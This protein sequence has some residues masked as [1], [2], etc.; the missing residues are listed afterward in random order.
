[1]LIDRA[2]I[3]RALPG[4]DIGG[5]IGR[6]GFGLVFTARHRRLGVTRAVKAIVAPEVD[7]AELSRRFLSEAQLMTEL[8]HP[9]LVRVFEYAEHGS[10]RLLVME[11]LAGGTLGQRLHQPVTPERVCAW[12]LAIADGLQAAHERGVAHRDIKPDNVLFTAGGAPKLSDFGIAK[13]FEGTAAST[14]G[15]LGTPIY[16]A[17]EQFLGAPVGPAADLYSLGA[18]LYRALADRTPVGTDLS[19][20]AVVRQVIEREPAP[21]DDVPSRVAAV[22]MRALAKKPSDRP[23][24]AQE[25]AVELARAARDSFG[26]GWITT[27]GVPLRV[28]PRVLLD[29]PAP[30]APTPQP[31]V[32][33]RISGGLS[34]AFAP[35][36]LA[37]APVAL[38]APPAAPA[39]AALSVPPARPRTGRRTAWLVAAAGLA[40]VALVLTA[41]YV[42]SR[43]GSPSA[44]VR[45]GATAPV[46]SAPAPRPTPTTATL[47]KTLSGHTDD[48]YAVAFDPKRPVIAS[49][50]K[51]GS[52]RF[53]NTRTGDPIGPARP[54]QHGNVDGLAYTADGR[55]LVTSQSDG[56]ILLWDPQI[57]QRRGDALTGHDGAVN[58][59]AVNRAGTLIASAGNDK[60]VRI[61]DLA[62]GKQ[63]VPALKGHTAEVT[64]V[65]FSPDGRLVASV[66]S[67]KTV[68]LWNAAT[69]AA[70]GG[71][72]TGH[73]AEVWSVAFNPDGNRLATASDDGTVRLWDVAT[74]AQV[75]S[76]L[77]GHNEGV[78]TVAFS[79]DGRLLA[80]AGEDK[81]L[82]LWNPNTGRLISFVATYHSDL[83]YNVAFSADSREI[84][85]AGAD[86]TVKLWQLA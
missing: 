73:T 11:Y 37:A 61:W 63:T 50:G 84:A 69:G 47:V 28:D 38:A 2:E 29:E 53:W 13:L 7:D 20:A 67:D 40:V 27:T 58:A 10:V 56:T 66:S 17:P 21:L 3:E 19:L 36:A 78:D 55:T 79:P 64:W 16:M 34:P 51:D 39:P 80:S 45:A 62:T 54:S 5:Q 72:M 41:G 86:H 9:H 74:R 83:I 77:T 32:P 8:D 24:S 57:G 42:G 49:G 71:P 15:L 26:R 81:S 4:Y 14:S 23:A 48:I 44:D 60:T 43:L 35:A 30:P 85:T 31:D 76:A 82:G 18:T 1:M 75:G 59:V 6:G 65:A 22:V 25:F 33:T 52:I 12:A 46:S 68:R 70:I